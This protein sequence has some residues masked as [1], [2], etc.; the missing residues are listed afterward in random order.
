MLR[1]IV[2]RC[3]LAASGG[4]LAGGCGSSSSPSPPAPS[5]PPPPSVPTIPVGFDAYRMWSRLPSILLGARTVMRSTYDRSGGNEASDASHFLR[6]DSGDE[7]VALD[8][9]GPGVLYF[10]RANLWHGS[11]WHYVVDGTDNVVSES[12]TADPD[13]PIPGSVFLPSAAFPEPLAFTWSTSAGSDLSWV[14]IPFQRSLVIADGRTYFGTGYYI[15]QQLP[16]GAED[17]SQPIETWSESSVP[18]GDVLDWIGSAGQ[19]IAPTGPAVST[20]AGTVT[21]A[22]GQTVT[23]ADLGPA[24][25]TIRALHLDVPLAS[26][27]A[28]ENATL[29]VTWD[30]RGAPS[31][32]APVPLFFGAGTLFNRSSAEYLVKGLLANIRFDA[33]AVHLAMYYPMPFFHRAQ[34]ELAAGAEPIGD[35]GFEVRTEPSDDLPA[36]TGYFHATYVD[37][38]VPV[39]GHDLVLL[40]TTQA[41]GG[42]SWCGSF[43]G[44]SFI[45]SE[46]A[47]LTTLEGDP[48]FFFD[49]SETPQAYGTGTEEWG[50]GGDYWGGLT[51]TLPFAGHPVGAPSPEAAVNAEDAVES[52]YRFLLA[53]AMPFGRNARI[54]LEHGGV[55]DS[56]EHYRTIAYWYGRPGA[57]LVPTDALHVGDP[58]DEAAHGYLSPTSSP[59]QSITSRYEWG[60]DHLDGVEIFPATTDTGRTMTGDTELTLAV[61]PANR[62]VLLRRK[63]DYQIADQRAEVYVATDAEGSAF[64][65]A[66]IWYLAGS[67]ACVFSFPATELGAAEDT[68]ETSDRRFRDDELLLPRRLTEGRSSIRL[69]IRFAPQLQPLVPGGGPPYAA[70]SELR[71]TAYSYVLDPR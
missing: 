5:A 54:Q 49:D 43:A 47:N 2:A 27:A 26:V 25:A 64:E 41:E 7:S 37:Q 6:R 24:P 52:A 17:A 12:A 71:Y 48:R 63:L 57:C 70:W 53:D 15:V 36:L 28:L 32:D 42:G 55:D 51:T 22:A 67:N 3:L 4:L 9:Q 44:T 38:G 18:P 62:G 20:Y 29:R 69:R 23:L 65:Y 16:D 1:R 46:A 61:D 39:P 40:D 59:V 35:V 66:G 8:L 21:V 11:P 13:Q 60:V 50:G 45:F 33:E 68:V 34:I 31:I 14:P 19:D 56:T 58:A 10:A 30:D